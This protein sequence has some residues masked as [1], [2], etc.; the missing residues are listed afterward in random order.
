MYLTNLNR[1]LPTKC[2]A[3]EELYWLCVDDQD[4]TTETDQPY[5]VECISDC[6]EYHSQFCSSPGEAVCGNDY[7]TYQNPW[8]MSKY[9]CDTRQITEYQ[10]H[11]Q[12]KLPGWV[13]L[14]LLCWTKV[15]K[16]RLVTKISP[17]Q[18]FHWAKVTNIWLVDKNFARRRISPNKTFHNKLSHFNRVQ[19]DEPK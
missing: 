16:L 18:Y 10:H 17:D 6:T 12:R 8:E 1:W 13:H 19:S 4:S 14:L 7:G 2:C 3:C 15:T 9:V 5:K 11:A